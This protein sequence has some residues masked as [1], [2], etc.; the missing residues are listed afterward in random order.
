[1]PSAVRHLRRRV[2]STESV[3]RSDV[4]AR[5]GFSLLEML[6]VLSILAA[7][8]L[9]AVQSLEPVEQQAKQ[10]ATRQ[11][12]EN[13]KKAILSVNQSG[14]QSVVAGFA[15][16]MGHLPDVTSAQT[17]AN[18]LLHNSPAL[19]LT[20]SLFGSVAGQPFGWRGAYLQ[21]AT[22]TSQ[23]LDAWNR[24]LSLGF[25]D[26]SGTPIVT[27]SN[28]SDRIVIASPGSPVENN[29]PITTTLTYGS[30][31]ALP[32]TVRLCA[33]DTAG[34]KTALSGTVSLTLAGGLST[35]AYGVIAE[36]IVPATSVTGL[37]AAFAF[38]PTPSQLLVGNR[39]LIVTFT[40]DVTMSTAGFT[41]IPSQTFHLNLIPGTSPTQE[42]IV[43][44]QN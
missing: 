40:A 39:D 17:F 41:V 13:V 19:G 42:V 37:D 28:A 38:Y 7:L 23:L 26:Y 9:I 14:G 29:G 18:D 43:A 1:M 36:T 34:M 5:G 30:L 20:R 24:P 31:T 22:T 3:L 15:A 2:R 6:I 8:T 33:T 27:L 32:L 25:F 21:T 11:T 44:R 4:A 12:L 35:T 10:H 16:D